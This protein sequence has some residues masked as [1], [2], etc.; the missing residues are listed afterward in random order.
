MSRSERLLDLLQAL[1]RRT[2]AVSA[3][4]LADELGV[5]LR[6]IYRDINTLRDQGAPIE[7]EAGVGFVLGPG[8]TLPPLH[9]TKA[10]LEALVLGARW[11]ASR[12]DTA[13]VRASA[14]CLAKVAAVLTPALRQELSATTMLVGPDRGPAVD[15]GLASAIRAS[16]A[17]DKKL[18]LSYKDKDGVSSVRLVWPVCVGF[19]DQVRVLVAWC[20]T[21]QAFRHFRL[22]RVVAWSEP[23]A[24]HPS[25]HRDLFVRW[26]QEEGLRPDAF[27][28]L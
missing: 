10:E 16:I 12:G 22:D 1:R 2:R 23:G 20:E 24:P 14:D 11:V 21:R 6:T 26:R 25:N 17:Q 13:L 28:L 9:F 7:G 15:D 18:E 4:V 8:F 5:N 3:A 27:E 19:F